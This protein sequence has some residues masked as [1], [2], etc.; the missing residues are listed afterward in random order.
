VPKK[1]ECKS[2]FVFWYNPQALQNSFWVIVGI[3]I[4]TFIYNNLGKK[5]KKVLDE[6]LR[7]KL[8]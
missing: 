3:I 8:Q 5:M 2:C 1:D 4:F 7:N 6:E